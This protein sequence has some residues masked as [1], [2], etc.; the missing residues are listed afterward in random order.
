MVLKKDFKKNSAYIPNID[1]KVV[2][3]SD[4]VLD[5]LSKQVVGSVLWRQSLEELN[6][7]GFENCF[8]LYHRRL[9]Y[10]KMNV[11][12]CLLLFFL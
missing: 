4:M 5:C 9:F 3:K 11:N 8:E 1:A 7:C 10:H 12:N 6:R 2:T